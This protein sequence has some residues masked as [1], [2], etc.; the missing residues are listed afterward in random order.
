M[1]SALIHKAIF[2]LINMWDNVNFNEDKG[3]I[4]VKKRAIYAFIEG[5]SVI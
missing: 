2:V 3:R 5:Y 4:S 1:P